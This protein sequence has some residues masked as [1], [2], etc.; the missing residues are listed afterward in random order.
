V[1]EQSNRVKSPENDNDLLRDSDFL[2]SI[3][4]MLSRSAIG[5]LRRAAIVITD[6]VEVPRLDR[7]ADITASAG[8]ESDEY[9][10]SEITAD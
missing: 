6:Y 2:N 7:S 4:R 9:S 5:D 1:T 8:T 10:E 3:I